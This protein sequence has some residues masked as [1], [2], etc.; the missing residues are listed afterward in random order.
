M[1]PRQNDDRP[2]RRRC[3]RFI[4]RFRRFV[5]STG[6]RRELDNGRCTVKAVILAGGRGTR[7]AEESGQRP[8]PMIEIGGRPLLWH[9]MKIYGRHGVT[10]FVVCLG[11]LGYMIKEFYANFALHGSD[12]T[13][14]IA[15]NSIEFHG[16]AREPWRVTLVETGLATQTGGRLKRIAPWVS[17]DDAFCMTYGDGVADIDLAELIAFHRQHGKLAT[18]TVVRPPG[19]FGSATLKADHV[20]GFTEKPRGDGGWIN[21]GFFVLAP[22]AL[23]RIADDATV[24]EQGPLESLAADDQLRAFR[25]DG[26]WQPM[27][28]MREKDQLEALWASGKAPWKTWA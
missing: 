25:H 16:S 17:D 23:D 13:V 28:T 6:G 9:I 2:L 12:F 11:Y 22:E 18:M 1:P 10:D 7:I 15:A 24:W 20:V 8:K 21:G 19:R 5:P 27:D 14:D 26:F 3:G 4:T